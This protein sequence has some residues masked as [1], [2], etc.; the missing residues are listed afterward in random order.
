MGRVIWPTD[1]PKPKRPGAQESDLLSL[2]NPQHIERSNQLLSLGSLRPNH[3]AVNPQ[4]KMGRG[5]G[6]SRTQRRHFRQNRENVWK[7]TKPDPSSDNENN[8]RDPSWQPFATQNPAFEEYYKV[9]IYDA[10]CM[11][12]E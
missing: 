4:P 1:Q 7:R 3:Q 10:V 6:G 11:L 2:Q 5:R 9:Y 8:G 12:L